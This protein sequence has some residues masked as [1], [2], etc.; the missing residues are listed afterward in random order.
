M[1]GITANEEKCNWYV[2]HSVSLATALNPKIGYARAADIAKRAIAAGKTIR[3]T[4]TGE[5][6]LSPEE[7]KG[8]LDSY[9][10]TEPKE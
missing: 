10:M 4:V 5:G 8:L 7:V 6:V 3:E 9:A 1:K 2:E